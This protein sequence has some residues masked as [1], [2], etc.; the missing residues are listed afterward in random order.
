[1]TPSFAL[2]VRC[3][4]N[5]RYVLLRFPENVENELS[6]T[7][8]LVVQLADDPRFLTNAARGECCFA[9]GRVRYQSGKCFALTHRFCGTVSARD[10]LIPLLNEAFSAKKRDEWWELLG[11]HGEMNALHAI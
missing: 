5:Q 2:C 9:L 4:A 6:L 3:W 7:H 10:E 1:M 8:S 11:G